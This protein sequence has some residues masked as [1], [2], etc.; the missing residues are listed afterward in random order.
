M[1]FKLAVSLTAR[2]QSLRRLGT[3]PL[4][5][6]KRNREVQVWFTYCTGSSVNRYRVGA[7]H[8]FLE[9]LSKNHGRLR[10]NAPD[11]TVVIAPPDIA[12]SALNWS[13]V[14]L[15]FAR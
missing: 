13:S 14:D 2:W 1:G 7:I 12:R 9:D 8:R 5:V 11:Q 10:A 3:T 15:I 4:V 6:L